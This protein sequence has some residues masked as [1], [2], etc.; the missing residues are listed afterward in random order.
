M[1]SVKI[2]KQYSPSILKGFEKTFSVIKS[3]GIILFDAPSDE[4]ANDVTAKTHDAR[5]SSIVKDYLCSFNRLSSTT[6]DA[7]AQ[8]ETI[9]G[10]YTVAK[11]LLN[12]SVVQ[13]GLFSTELR[14]NEAC[15]AL[16]VRELHRASLLF[17]QSLE[18]TCVALQHKPSWT[19]VSKAELGARLHCTGLS[20][21]KLSK[22]L[23]AFAFFAAA[24][25]VTDLGDRPHLWIRLAECCLQREALREGEAAAALAAA[26]Q[27]P[28]VESI[29]NSRT[30]RVF[31]RPHTSDD[32]SKDAFS[33]DTATDE[34]GC[35]LASGVV[36]LKKALNLAVRSAST[37][38]NSAGNALLVN[39]ILLRLGFACLKLR[40]C[41]SALTYA[42]RLDS[43]L[44]SLPS[45][46]EN[47]QI[48]YLNCSYLV[49]ALCMLGK[50]AEANEVFKTRV[51][52]DCTDEAILN[53]AVPPKSF[54]RP[55]FAA[56]DRGIARAAQQV[57]KAIVLLLRGY[58]SAAL[59]LVEAALRVCAD[60]APAVRCLLFIYMRQGRSRH[61]LN[62]MNAYKLSNEHL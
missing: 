33:G 10:N 27:T 34:K 62:V 60:Y 16:Y 54:L 24:V 22:P 1:S 26:P 57:N 37:V 44:C 23:D 41:G 13:T 50:F 11:T 47:L 30:R 9:V 2:T 20:L 51:D 32:L 46:T 55:S 58:T 59:T 25:T 21:L 3:P 28:F 42:R 39:D 17:H 14:H 49:Q 38:D 35:D 4:A 12:E 19:D 36:Y 52:A 31:L 40:D 56:P 8:I 61:A 18:S 6:I 15:V 48:K 29:S 43:R 53:C 7:A 45:S 5:L